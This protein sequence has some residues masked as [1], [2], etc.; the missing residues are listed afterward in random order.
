M[1]GGCLRVA[2]ACT[3]ALISCA[4]ANS[5]LAQPRT[6]SVRVDS[7]VELLSLVFRLAGA[8]EY[9]ACHLKGYETDEDEAFGRFK[10]HAAV[11]LARQLHD[12]HDIG[13]DAVMSFAVSVTDPP[14]LSARVPFGRNGAGLEDPR[15][16]GLPASEFLTALRQFSRDAGFPQFV[17]RHRSLYIATE[18]RLE[19]L[20][21]EHVAL[22]WYERFFGQPADA[23]FMLVAGMCNG[24][25]NFG[26]K[27]R[28]EGG[29][30]ELYAIVGVTQSDADGVPTF[31]PTLVPTIVHE[32][33][34]SFVNPFVQRHR[35]EL[36]TAGERIYPAVA[37]MMQAQAYGNWETMIIESLVRAVVV[38][39]LRANG[40][41]GRATSQLT[42]EFGLGF[43]WI[44]D[45]DRLLQ[46]Y[47][48]QRSTFVRFDDVEPQIA[49]FF[50]DVSES[51][52]DRLKELDNRRPRIVSISPRDG[53]TG[54]DPS[55]RRIVVVFDRPM[56]QRYSINYGPG[57]KPRYPEVTR[58]G[59][60]PDHKTFIMD[61]R[62]QPSTQY[63]LL[64]TGRGFRSDDGIPLGQRLIR[65]QTGP[66]SS[67]PR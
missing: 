32:F 17:A 34:H 47:E 18:R 29:R 54:V 63:E 21:R 57:G 56:G 25:A 26:P 42:E 2:L 44:E 59:F 22:Q 64:F 55:T 20:T 23:E 1:N 27:V 36:V 33:A 30:E 15:W 24:G 67:V 11:R 9:N 4:W 46:Q 14:A 6:F 65:F 13:F 60:E 49:K 7:R 40:D 5:A 61:V 58:V 38:R 50:G 3:V 8:A 10:S 41:S 43:V 16:H 52:Q 45:L 28:P 37:E 35:G 31:D 19:T 62:L 48:Q 66:G 39:Y 51:I 53:E 12:E